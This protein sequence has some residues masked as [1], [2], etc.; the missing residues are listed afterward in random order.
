MNLYEEKENFFQT[1]SYDEFAPASS[2]EFY[3]ELF[4]LGSF[5]KRLGK[6]AEYPKTNIGNGFIVYTTSADRK[7]TRMVFDDLAEIFELQDNECAFMSPC[8]Y[9]GKNRTAKNARLLYA[10]AFDLDGVGQEQ[11]EIFF[12]F[13]LYHRHY[14]R[15]TY[16]VNSGGGVHLYYFFEKPLPMTPT[17]QRSLKKIKY[18]LTKI[19]WNVDTSLI[20]NPQYQGLNQ[21]FRL[22]GGL[23]KNG[24]R[25]TAWRTG[26]RIAV[27]ELVK[28]IPKDLQVEF[29]IYSSKI[30]LEQA[31]EKYPDWYKE[32]IV[33]G[34][35][36]MSWTNKRALYDWWKT[37][38]SLVKFHHRYF[39]IMSLTI[40]AVKCGIEFDELKKDAFYFMKFFNQ[41]SKEPF[42]EQDVN[43]ALKMYS[44]N[45]K[46][47][48]R[49]EIAKITAIPIQPNKRNG[50]PQK[51]HLEIARATQA[52]QEKY[53]GTNWREGNGRK[54]VKDAVFNFLDMNPKA[55]YKEFCELTSLQKSSFYKYKK[56]WKDEKLAAYERDR[57]QFAI[58]SLFDNCIRDAETG[59]PVDLLQLITGIKPPTE[60]PK[61]T[62]YLP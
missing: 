62:D 42:T 13:H 50:R 8:S 29:K 46:S 47:F 44:E 53:N 58:A 23:T 57:K 38:A 18:A 48:P 20:V 1:W 17:N 19:M 41:S 25:V 56:I 6:L 35:K 59:E 34:R 11:L 9:F 4:P 26:E 36:K 10:L 43:A 49:D 21:G 45:Y 15:P 33:Q 32:R 60:P 3:R 5:E 28:F 61:L 51:Q 12:G 52:I 30:S 24:E 37:K 16:I 39:Y 14:P 40:Y 54:S 55:T 7:R 27:A 22:V 2:S 31:K